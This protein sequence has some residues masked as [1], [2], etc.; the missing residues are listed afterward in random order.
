MLRLARSF[1]S[2]DASAEEV[3]Q[4][5]WLAVLQGI[6]G[7]QGRSTLRTWVYRILVNTAK[8]RG[9]LESRTVP[10][11]SLQP[12]GD[13]LARSVG[14]AAFR[15]PED[16]YPRHWKPG[17]VPVPWQ[18]S[19]LTAS[20][21]ASA[22]AREIRTLLGAALSSLPERQRIVV[23]L[24]DVHGHERLSHAPSVPRL[25]ELTMSAPAKGYQACGSGPG[26]LT[27]PSRRWAGASVA[28][29]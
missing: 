24:R 5:T 26:S 1:V 15:G 19:T 4:D 11:A 8:K 22:L 13:D 29:S 16:P 25:G 20:S 2:S 3:V 14:P 10:W 7:F 23:T 12:A 28:M 18:S 21:E 17:S 9:V 6:D 27:H